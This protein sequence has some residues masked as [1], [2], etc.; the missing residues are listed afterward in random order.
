MGTS[1]K[2]SPPVAME[3]RLLAIE[4][5]ETGLSPDEVETLDSQEAEKR[6]CRAGRR[7]S[8]LVI[9]AEDWIQALELQQ[10]PEG[11]WF[12]EVYRAPETIPTGGLPGRFAGERS[13][14][15]AIY[16]LLEEPD[17][18]PRSPPLVLYDV[19]PVASKM[20]V[21]LFLATAGAREP[22]V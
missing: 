1:V 17:F 8:R 6:V 20:V 4:A 19:F 18:S 9:K 21:P 13:F 16:Y 10:H 14:S 5:L 3:V 2:R 22:T 7:C 11:G 15:T 12:R